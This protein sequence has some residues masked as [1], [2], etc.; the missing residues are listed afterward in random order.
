M[1]NCDAKKYLDTEVFHNLT[2]LLDENMEM[3]NNCDIFLIEQQMNRNIMALKIGQH[4]FSYFLFKFGRTKQV[5]E[6]ASYHKTQ[7]LNAPRI[8]VVK[9]LKSGVEKTSFRCMTK[10]ERKKWSV[11]R[12]N[13]I[14]I[15]RNDTSSLIKLRKMK[16]CDDVSDCLLMIQAYKFLFI[17]KQSNELP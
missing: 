14:L 5:V 12:A 16:K 15:K 3:W 10:P 11:K 13:E 1:K 2:E 6:F 8:P 17:K 4:C 7:V 9:R